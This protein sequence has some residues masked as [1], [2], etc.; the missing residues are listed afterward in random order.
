[1]RAGY[2]QSKMD[3]GFSNPWGYGEDILKVRDAALKH[4]LATEK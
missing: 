2:F 4:G 3:N 1:M